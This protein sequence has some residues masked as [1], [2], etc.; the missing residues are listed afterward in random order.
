[1]TAGRHAD[2]LDADGR[3]AEH[4]SYCHACVAACHAELGG[5]EE[6]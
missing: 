3:I 6:A 2:A 4:P 1:M 5:M